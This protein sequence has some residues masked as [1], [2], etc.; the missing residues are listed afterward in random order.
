MAK[1]TG[2]VL[3]RCRALG[4]QP[5]EIGYNK[6]S[7]RGR[8]LKKGKKQK[9]YALQLREKQKVKFIYGVLEKQFRKYFEK[10]EKMRGITGENM[11]ILLERRI[12]NVVYRLGMAKTRPQARQMVNHG[13][14]TVN[15]NTLDIPSALISVGDVISVKENKKKSTMWDSVKAEKNLGILPWLEFDNENLVGKVIALPKRE[16]IKDVDI[17]EHL[18]VG[19]YSK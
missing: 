19:L 7:E 8:I 12:D 10:A 4:I 15:G 11:L 16:D 6:K 3:K 5:I 13:L 9:G 14:I 17:K 18:I 1:Y 2:P